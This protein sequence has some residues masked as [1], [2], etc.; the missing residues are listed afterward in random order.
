MLAYIRA[1]VLA[2]AFVD[3]FWL[4]YTFADRRIREYQRMISIV[5]LGILIILFCITLIP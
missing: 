3:T 4:G 1:G 2:W 5:I